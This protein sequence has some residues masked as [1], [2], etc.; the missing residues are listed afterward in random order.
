MEVGTN[1]SSLQTK[2]LA[3]WMTSLGLDLNNLTSS[4]PFDPVDM[5]VRCSLD[6]GIPVLLT[7]SL[8]N[9]IMVNNKRLIMLELNDAYYTWTVYKTEA[10]ISSIMK[11]QTFYERTLQKY[12]V[13]KS[14]LAVI[15][16]EIM[17]YEI[18]A[19][20]LLRTLINYTDPNLLVNDENPEDVCYKHANRL[21]GYAITSR[22]YHSVISKNT[23]NEVREI[24]SNIRKAY[25]A[26]FQ[27]SSWM[28]GSVRETALKKIK[29]MRHHFGAV[30]ATYVEKYYDYGTRDDAWLRRRLIKVLRPRQDV[31]N[32][33]VDSENLGDLG[34]TTMAYSAF[35]S[36]PPSKRDITLPGVAM[37]ANQ[38]FFVGH[39]TP[40]CEKR[41]T[42]SPPWLAGYD[43]YPP[44]RSRCIVPLMNMPEF[45]DA[46]HCK[47][48]SYMNPPNKCMFWT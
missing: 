17:K 1:Y 13:D 25:Q 26:A 29:K 24:A 7:F 35:T 32:D 23:L 15:V 16:S 38:L 47:Q 8:K 36:L 48:G 46:F 37:T 44:G 4:E 27:S 6:F 11:L 33:T 34:G 45:S 30:D 19:W 3:A 22:F 39:C 21:M 40:W 43:R 42:N 14:R 2:E 12:G 5:L 18:E 28:T 9:V 41:T 10:L 31:L 20:G